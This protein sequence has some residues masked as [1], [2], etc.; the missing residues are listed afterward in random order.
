MWF[1][2]NEFCQCLMWSTIEMVNLASIISLCLIKCISINLNVCSYF[3]FN[4]MN[5]LLS[6]N[7]GIFS[8]CPH[9]VE[10]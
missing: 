6:D 10:F 1:G 4:S 3:T 8:P 5:Q 7:N 2:G 9:S